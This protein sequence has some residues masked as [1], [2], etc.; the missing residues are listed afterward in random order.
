MIRFRILATCFDGSGAPIP[1]TWYGHAKNDADAITQMTHEAQSNSWG[2]G[3]I[4]SVQQRAISTGE[5]P[6]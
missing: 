2:I 6:Q 1:V 3:S 5:V 4:I